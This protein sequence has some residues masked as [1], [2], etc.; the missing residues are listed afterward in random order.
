[1]A[2]PELDY[3]TIKGFKSF[4]SMEKLRLR[5]INVV[6]GPNGSGK[7][8]FLGLFS[9]LNAIREGKLQD[10]VSTA[11]GAEKVLHFGS[12]ST[13]LIEIH[14]SFQD[15][16]NEY[17]IEFGP[18]AG[19]QLASAREVAYFWDKEKHPG[20]PYDEP[21]PSRGPEAGISDP[22]CKGVANFV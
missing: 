11:G 18:V 5:A 1:M 19:D 10:Y 12:R 21:L 6:I 20:K 16:V 13:N 14:L 9:F 2:S 4:A 7:S 17:R 8:N 15:E 3:I 22:N